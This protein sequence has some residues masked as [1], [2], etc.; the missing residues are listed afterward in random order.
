MNNLIRY[1]FPVAAYMAFIFFLSSSPQFPFEAPAWMFYADKLAH[2]ILYGVL[3]F[4]FL[5]ALTRGNYSTLTL[6]V[7][8]LSVLLTSLY[9]ITDEYHQSF[10]PG[11]NPDVQDWM[12]DTLGAML[13]CTIAFIWKVKMKPSE[14]QTDPTL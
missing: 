2:F 1:W 3:G 8:G 9:G 7:L 14:R 10:V 6:S 4:L 13:V 5:R 11:R 12:A